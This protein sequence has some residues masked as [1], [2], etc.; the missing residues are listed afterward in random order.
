[1]EN[2]NQNQITDQIK[3]KVFGERGKAKKLYQLPKQGFSSYLRGKLPTW[4]RH[5]V[6][7]NCCYCYT[8][9]WINLGDPSGRPAPLVTEKKNDK[10]EGKIYFVSGQSIFFLSIMFCSPYHST[11]SNA[12]TVGI[13]QIQH[14][15]RPRFLVS[16]AEFQDC[17]H[18]FRSGIFTVVRRTNWKTTTTII[19]YLEEPLRHLYQELHKMLSQ[20]W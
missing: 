15:L 3:L 7:S 20:V 8:R 10:R 4:V 12:H 6:P 5:T 17:K 2:I 14:N 16:I 18:C 11:C 9:H 19:G 1:M 13:V